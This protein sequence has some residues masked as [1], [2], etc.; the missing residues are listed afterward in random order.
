M[1]L[2]DEK[3][4]TLNAKPANRLG[5]VGPVGGVLVVAAAVQQPVVLS[6][7]GGL[8]VGAVGC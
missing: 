6:R 1:K 7:G 5:G 8:L 2:L 3:F 4:A